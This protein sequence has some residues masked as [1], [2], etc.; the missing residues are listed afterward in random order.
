MR[1]RILGL[2]LEHGDGCVAGFSD[3]LHAFF[4]PTRHDD[5]NTWGSS[6][7]CPSLVVM[8]SLGTALKFPHNPHRLPANATDDVT[9]VIIVTDRPRPRVVTSARGM[10]TGVNIYYIFFF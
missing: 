8:S 7:T 1:S 5:P 6:T 3:R 2:F 10:T 4:P 9:V